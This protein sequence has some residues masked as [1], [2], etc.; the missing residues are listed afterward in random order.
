MTERTYHGEIT[1]AD[2]ST[3]LIAAFNQGN[4]RCLQVGQGDK[5]MIQIATRDTPHSG[6][7][8]RCRS[9]SNATR[10]V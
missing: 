4:L 2:M 7:R 6:A 3:A 1:P 10:T 9:L 8:A 5:I